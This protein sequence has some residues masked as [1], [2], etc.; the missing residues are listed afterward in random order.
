MTEVYRINRDVYKAIT[1]PSM[2]SF[3]VTDVR[4]HIQSHSDSYGSVS[5]ARQLVARELDKLEKAGLAVGQGTRHNKTYSKTSAFN[6]MRFDLK[7]KR[8]ISSKVATAKS[9]LRSIHSTL[10]Q[11]KSDIEAELTIT[12]EE[13]KEYKILKKRSRELCRLLDEPHSNAAKK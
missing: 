13:L 12:L 11:E 3:R 10:Q 1:H 8:L 5:N 9:P 4:K 6:E 2:S 7:E